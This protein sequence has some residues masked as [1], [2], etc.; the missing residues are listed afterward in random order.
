MNI[1]D[2]CK[3]EQKLLRNHFL[4]FYVNRKMENIEGLEKLQAHTKVYDHTLLL[5][6]KCFK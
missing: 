4:F 6:D 5:M 1:I 2:K 3:D